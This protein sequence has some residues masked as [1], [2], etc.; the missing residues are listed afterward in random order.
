MRANEK[1]KYSETEKNTTQNIAE[2]RELQKD[3]LSIVEK[4]NQKNDVK[5]GLN[6][7]NSYSYG[8]YR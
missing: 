6:N 5:Q 4:F 1:E 7:S 8:S 3:F 2:L